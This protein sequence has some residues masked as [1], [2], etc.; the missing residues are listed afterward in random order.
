M[1]FQEILNFKKVVI[2]TGYKNHLIEK[3]LNFKNLVFIKNKKYFNTNMVESLF[4]T[5]NEIKNEDILIT[6]ADIIFDTKI[7]IN[8]IKIKKNI[9]NG[10]TRTTRKPTCKERSSFF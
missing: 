8:L 10:K 1:E 7:L 6:Y 4:L 3:K 5:K 2:V 9:I